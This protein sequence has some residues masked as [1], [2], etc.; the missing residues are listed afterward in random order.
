MV[1]D[2]NIIIACLKG[3]PVASVLSEWKRESRA[4]FISSITVAETLS[5]PKLS[6]SEIIKIRA[7]L[8]NFISAPFDDAIAELAATLRRS[9]GLE[10]P[11]AGIAATALIRALPLATR[12]KQFLKIKEIKIIA[13]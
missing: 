12:D 13:I 1:V 10:I 4:L 3:E 5:L 6:H 2:T 8:S 9:Y 7:F 11:D